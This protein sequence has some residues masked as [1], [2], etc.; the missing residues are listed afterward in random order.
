MIG[1]TEESVVLG[2]C[3]TYLYIFSFG[4]SLGPF[5]VAYLTY[6]LPPQLLSY[7]VA[8]QWTVATII[9]YFGLDILEKMDL[10]VLFGILVI[11]NV[12]GVLYFSAY[13]I[14][15]EGKTEDEIYL[16]FKNKRFYS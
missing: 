13:G 16:S 15:T 8:V 12:F 6:I 14:E 4:F 11:F 9:V 2:L 5:V 10:I 7:A 3:G 1:V